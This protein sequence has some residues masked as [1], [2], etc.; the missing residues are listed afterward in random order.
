[1]TYWLDRLPSD[2]QKDS[3]TLWR[4]GRAI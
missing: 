2:N 4:S 1:M 3:R